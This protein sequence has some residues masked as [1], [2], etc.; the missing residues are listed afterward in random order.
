[1]KSWKE[2]DPNFEAK[3]ERFTRS[4]IEQI[5]S[6]SHIASEFSNFAKMP[7]TRLEKVNL[8]EIIGQS[9]ILYS[10]TDDT[11][12][13]FENTCNKKAIVI[14]DRDQLLR[15][16]NN[17]IKNAIEARSG[18]RPCIIH[19]LMYCKTSSVCI[20]IKD[21]GN[22]IVHDLQKKIFVPNFTTKSSGTGLGLAFVKQAIENMGGNI[23]FETVPNMGTTFYITVP[24]TESLR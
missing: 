9:I 18:K 10:Q 20:E 1:E 15:C 14:A 2:M 7:E 4:S 22:G 17:L 21:N 8:K 24:F 5:E 19:I 11:A 16:F 12:I 3:F 23:R 13:N 6:L